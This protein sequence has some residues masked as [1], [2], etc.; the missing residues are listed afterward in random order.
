MRRALDSIP[1]LVEPSLLRRAL[2]AVLLLL[3]VWLRLQHLDEHGSDVLAV[4]RDAIRYALAGG[5]PYGHGYPSSTP[6]GAP[7]AYGPLALLYYALMPERVELLA[8][9]LVLA[10]LAMGN[11]LLGL[12]CLAVWEPLWILASDGSNDSSVGLLL[13]GALILAGRRPQAGAAALAAV[14]AF[15]PYALAFLPPLL[16]FGGW[17]LL[18]P[19]LMA[20]VA[21]WGP[22]LV[23]WGPA[24][25]LRSLQGAMEI[26]RAPWYSLAAFLEASRAQRP[27]F[28]IVQVGTGGL[29][30]LLSLRWARSPR[31]VAGWGS[32]IF[33]GTLFTGWWATV[34]YWAAIAP[35]LAWYLDS[36]IV[37]AVGSAA[38]RVPRV[39]PP[40]SARP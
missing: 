36:W 18:A 5:N 19:F 16:A 31:A 38:R 15:K 4:T 17:S 37:D 6:A 8:S 25:I 9:V 33:A 27:L 14:V 7:Y 20:S 28:A 24:A 32:V 39:P 30:A 29:L 23:A 11:R 35:A 22:A 2:I 40:R 1:I 34:A 12:A 10:L 13:L 21:A 3:G 26:H